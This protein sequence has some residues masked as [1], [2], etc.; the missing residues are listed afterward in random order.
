[1]PFAFTDEQLV[2]IQTVAAP[3]PVNLRAAF[4]EA[5]AAE[6]AGRDDVGAGELHR[7]ALEARR[8]VAPWQSTLAA[9]VG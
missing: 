6:L 5:L 7:L 8:R 3:I 4:L 1:M 2:T 9:N